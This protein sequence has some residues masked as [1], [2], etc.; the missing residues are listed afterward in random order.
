MITYFA[1]TDTGLVRDLNEDCFGADEACKLWLVADGVGGHNCGEVASEIVRSTI[2]QEFAGGST[3]LRCIEAAHE[4]VLAEMQKYTEKSGMGST[5]VAISID[6]DTYNIAWVGDSR[7]YLWNG[8]I[9]MLTTDHTYVAGLVKKGLMSPAAAEVHPKRHIITQ[10]LGISEDMQLD[11]GMVSGKV[12]NGEQFLLCSDGLTTGVPD[13]IIA[14]I[15][16]D[17]QTPEAQVT[18]LMS[19]AL[20]AGGR[21]NVTIVSLEIQTEESV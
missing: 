1:K 18:K 7:A 3:M 19:E 10:S 5:V 6:D 17:E 2:I 14:S 20:A 9:T 12:Q 16:K 13:E 21:D 11:V 8:E 4:A 15:M